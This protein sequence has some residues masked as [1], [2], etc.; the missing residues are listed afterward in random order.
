MNLFKVNWDRLNVLLL[1]T[2]LRKPLL[3]AF[4]KA[5]TAPIWTIYKKFFDNRNETMFIL[6]YDTSKG[7]LE[8][9]LNTRFET[10]GIYVVNTEVYVDERVFLSDDDILHIEFYIGEITDLTTV[11]RTYFDDT[12]WI[13]FYIDPKIALAD[14]IIMV[15]A[16]VDAIFH[17]QIV[18]FAQFLTLPGFKYSITNY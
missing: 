9:S 3:F 6:K 10:D 2:F 14:F 17:D 16:G 15:P 1:P 11:E 5:T 18:R 8:R 12:L 4:L 13:D 7:N